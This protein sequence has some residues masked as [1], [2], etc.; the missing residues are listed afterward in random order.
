MDFL[1]E[2]M[3]VSQCFEAN[4]NIVSE[5]P[6]SKYIHLQQIKI[7]DRQKSTAKGH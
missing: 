6:L 7:L 5:T 4:D 3:A 1:L 2:L